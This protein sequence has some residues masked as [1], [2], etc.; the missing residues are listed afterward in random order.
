VTPG[1]VSDDK[2]A[3]KKSIET[4]GARKSKVKQDK[5]VLTE[6]NNSNHSLFSIPNMDEQKAM[7]NEIYKKN[8][9]TGSGKAENKDVKPF[10]AGK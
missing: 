10:K 3:D 6:F 1:E 4:S 5:T 9:A 2:A 7:L 8:T